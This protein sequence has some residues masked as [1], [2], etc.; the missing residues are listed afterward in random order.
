MTLLVRD[1]APDLIL[2]NGQVVTLQ[3]AL[4]RCTAQCSAVEPSFC[5]ALTFTFFASSARTAAT[6]PRME[7]SAISLFTGAAPREATAMATRQA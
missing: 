1:L 3:E 5:G 2:Y 7:A 6:S 4:P